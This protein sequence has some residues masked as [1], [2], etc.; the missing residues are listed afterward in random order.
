MEFHFK[1][2]STLETWYEILSTSTPKP[3]HRLAGN[4]EFVLSN[5]N[6]DLKSCIICN[7]YF[8]GIFFQGYKCNYCDFVLHLECLT[9][10]S[11][12]ICEVNV[13][14]LKKESK[15]GANIQFKLDDV[16]ENLKEKIDYKKEQSCDALLSSSSK[17]NTVK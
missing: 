5:F 13:L 17:E 3:E 11:L 12:K 10:S 9:S 4:H 8:R 2:T 1:E 14:G 6:R 15:L 16:N 7:G